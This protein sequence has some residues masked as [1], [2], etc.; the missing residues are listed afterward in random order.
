MYSSAPPHTRRNARF[1]K[2]LPIAAL[3]A[4]PQV[5]AST[6]DTTL[7]ANHC[8]GTNGGSYN[9]NVIVDEDLST[10]WGVVGGYSSAGASAPIEDSDTA[11]YNKLT[12]TG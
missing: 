3:L 6:C 4:A 1:L 8:I 2:L 11:S 7:L 5:W 10:L 12:V 9:T